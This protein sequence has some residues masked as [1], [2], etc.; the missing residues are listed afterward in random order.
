[1]KIIPSTNI[2]EVQNPVASTSSCRN[3][4]SPIPHA[5]RSMAP[6]TTS[7]T[8]KASRTTVRPVPRPVS[9]RAMA[10][11]PS[12]GK[13]PAGVET[14]AGDLGDPEAVRAALKGVRTLF[15][16]N[17]VVPDELT[18]ALMVL[19]LARE[20]GIE[21]IIYFSV[22]KA[23]TEETRIVGG[24]VRDALLGYVSSDVDLATTLLPKEVMRRA[25]ATSLRAIPTGIEHGTVTILPIPLALARSLGATVADLCDHV[26]YIVK[27]CGVAHVG[28]SSDFDGG[29]AITGWMDASES[30]NVTAELVRRGYGATEIEAMWSGNFLRLLTAAETYADAQ[31]D[32]A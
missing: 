20:A 5:C 24:A 10:R 32:A 12:K 16:L 8:A 14:A 6:A 11:D 21:R 31:R 13:F 23:E 15:L 28:I 18:Q 2:A 30:G 7:T 1:M 26:D 17:A 19:G 25:T 27:R 4:P 29:G 22:L 3:D 9:V